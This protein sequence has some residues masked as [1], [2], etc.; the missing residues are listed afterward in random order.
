MSG[1]ED[2]IA[3]TDRGV[4]PHAA[5]PPDAWPY[6]REFNA[7]ISLVLKIFGSGMSWI[8]AN[9]VPLAKIQDVSLGEAARTPSRAR[10]LGILL[11]N[12]RYT[13]A[14]L[15]N[16]CKWFSSAAN[17]SPGGLYPNPRFPRVLQNPT[18]LKNS[19]K[20]TQAR[21]TIGRIGSHEQPRFQPACRKR[22]SH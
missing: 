20:V 10:V 5:M 15:A 3:A 22:L 13:Y 21:F 9:G 7:S 6:R 4:C 18:V 17:S 1:D 8:L 19:C 16:L 11:K 2:T 12:I 14:N